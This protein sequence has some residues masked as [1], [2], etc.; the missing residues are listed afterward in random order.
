[1]RKTPSASNVAMLAFDK[2][3]PRVIGSSQ[4]FIVIDRA[5]LCRVG[6]GSAY[7]D[8]LF[9]RSDGTVI[10]RPRELER[11]AFL[12][13]CVKLH[14]RIGGDRRFENGGEYR[15]AV[16]FAR[17]PVDDLPW[18]RLAVFV[19]PLTGLHYVRQQ[20]LDLDDFA[21]LGFLGK[22]APRLLFP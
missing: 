15:F 14:V 18:N 8:C 13:L 5:A 17:E 12:D 19:L 1:M 16:K 20:R 9:R 21:F 7:R 6:R 22:L 4:P 11:A 10:I 2:I 3:P